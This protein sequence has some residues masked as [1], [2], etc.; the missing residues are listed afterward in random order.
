M[1][2]ARSTTIATNK[3]LLILIATKT[4]P[5]TILNSVDISY[6]TLERRRVRTRS[7]LQRRTR[8][9][10]IR[11]LAVICTFCAWARGKGTQLRQQTHVQISHTISLK[12]RL[13]RVFSTDPP[14]ST[15]QARPLLVYKIKT[16][17]SYSKLMTST[18]MPS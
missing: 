9:R 13:S 4:N 12:C 11:L 16:L 6:R 5:R 14:S 2:R 1:V 17:K 10:R 3:L 15:T 18:P 7:C 8:S